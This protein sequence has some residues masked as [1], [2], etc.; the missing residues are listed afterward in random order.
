MVGLFVIWSNSF[1]AIK[2][3]REVLD[4]MELVLARFLPVGL[5]SFVYLISSAKRRTESRVLLQGSWIQIIVM[6][7]VGV[8]GYNYFLSLGQSEI[9]PG[10]AALITSL[11]PLFTAILAALL[12]KERVPLRRAAGIVIAFVG[13]YFVIRWGSV[14][15]GRVNGITNAE[16]KYALI[17]AVAP[18]CWSIYSI[19]GKQLAGKGSALTITYLSLVI[20]TIPVLFTLDGDFVAKLIHMGPSYWIALL[21]LSV[22]CTII[23][24]YIW[25][26]G[27][28]YLPATAVA[29]YVFLN[30]PFAAFFG[31]LLFGEEVTWLF[32]AGSVVVLAGLYLTQS[33][34]M[35]RQDA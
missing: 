5:F 14:G 29:S 26:T 21:Y 10:A 3:L 17:A 25:V 7:I 15:M 22:L 24:F 12:L 28:K 6:A 32:L 34:N 31:W 4:P 18:F 23:G 1:T 19:A 11:V 35:R 27:L 20:G 33:E 16:L 8:W 9:K 30:P 13:L 2:H